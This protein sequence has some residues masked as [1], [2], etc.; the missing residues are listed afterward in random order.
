[1]GASVALSGLDRWI[2][3]SPPPGSFISL[4]RHQQDSLVLAQ[5]F[6]SNILIRYGDPIN[7]KGETFGFNCDFISC[8]SKGPNEAILWVNH[9][10]PDPL[11][12]SGYQSGPKSREQVLA[13]QMSVGGSLLKIRRSSANAAWFVD[14]KDP[15][16]QRIHGRTSIKIVAERPIAGSLLAMG[17]MANCSGGQTPW[18]NFL[19]CEENFDDYYGLD[20]IDPGAPFGW[21]QHDKNHPHHYGWVVE[22]NS[23]TG[24]AKKLA[25]LG[26][27]AHESATCTLAADGRCVVYSGD[28]ARD[29]FVYKFI[30]RKPG[31]LDEGE[32]FAAD[33]KRGRWLSLN[34]SKQ[35]L[36]QAN[37]KDQTD[38][39][40]HT[41]KAAALLGA[42]PMNRPEDIERHP[43]TGE[44]FI[45]LTGNAQRGDL[46]GSLLKLK[47]NGN[48][49]LSLEFQSES[50]LMGGPALGFACPDNLA[51]DAQG[52]LWMTN[53]IGG[54][55]LNQREF[56]I[57][58]NNS[59]FFIPTQGPHA[60]K[61]FKVASA[62]LFAEFTGPC[63]SP[64]A[65]RLFLSVQHPGEG[66]K[67][68]ENPLS[69]WPD[70]GSST[71]R[72]SVIQI[73]IPSFV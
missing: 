67:S 12:V 35:K 34:R 51:F 68:L 10:Y 48:D 21:A 42:T 44:I 25:A 19:S 40:I 43:V 18:G 59:L 3:A 61:I 15:L 54:K 5:D 32:L 66:S 14:L 63:L 37:F 38:V 29:Q 9:E 1:M 47:E 41:R 53:D 20:E 13:E 11:F 58:G 57:F 70:G 31:S 8:L 46:Y 22:I 71:P 7:S 16:N 45:A 6:E 65:Q 28:D 60:G 56:E 30:S 33:F 27:F 24:E 73:K 4:G 2:Y 55:N 50:F 52:N 39:L 49:P 62:P 23:G 72:P 69:R 64:D 26:R 17:T 36:L